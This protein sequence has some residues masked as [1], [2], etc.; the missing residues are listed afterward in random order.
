MFVRLEALDGS[1]ECRAD[2]VPSVNTVLHETW[3]VTSTVM[4]LINCTTAW[5]NL[6]CLGHVRAFVFSTRDLR[7]EK[8]FIAEIL[9]L[10]GPFC[11]APARGLEPMTTL[12]FDINFVRRD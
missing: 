9:E 3:C 2:S 5:V 12:M 11:L 7:V 6:V 4:C 8:V 10:L 1:V